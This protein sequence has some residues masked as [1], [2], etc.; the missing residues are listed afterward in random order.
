MFTITIKEENNITVIN[1]KRYYT[2]R[3]KFQQQLIITVTPTNIY[4]LLAKN[5]IISGSAPEKA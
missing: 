5:I 1:A 4:I 2:L 3:N